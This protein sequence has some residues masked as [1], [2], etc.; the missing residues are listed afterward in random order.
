MQI[1]TNT[2]TS[3]ARVCGEPSPSRYVFFFSLESGLCEGK[4]CVLNVNKCA[5][6][7][8][9]QE[10]VQPFGGCFNMVVEN[11][12]IRIMFRN[13]NRNYFTSSVLLV[14]HSNRVWSFP[15]GKWCWMWLRKRVLPVL[16]GIMSTGTGSQP[17][18]NQIYMI[19]VSHSLPCC[20]NG[21]S[22]QFKIESQNWRQSKL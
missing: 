10:L 5:A 12:A 19:F 4:L 21:A 1:Y 13:K 16:D 3:P 14:K 20:Y 18:P 17:Y 6:A 11:A 7:T 15:F 9:C 8:N 22:F 2:R